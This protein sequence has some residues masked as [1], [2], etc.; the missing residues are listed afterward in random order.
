[1]PQQFNDDARALLAGAITAAATSL[2]IESTKADRF[3]VSNTASWAAKD[4]WFKATLVDPAT[5]S[6]EVVYVGARVAGSGACTNLLRGQ[7]GTAARAWN[8]GA[9]I[10]HGPLASDFKGALAGLFSQFTA[11]DGISAGAAWHLVGG[12]LKLA[13][14]DQLG[15]LGTDRFTFDQTTGVFTCVD[16]AM[17]SDERDKTGWRGVG[18]H[19]LQRL[20]DVRRGSFL[21]KS[22]GRRELGVS[23]QSLKPVMPWA[24]IK[25]AT[26]GELQVR[27][28]QAALV[29]A[30]E[31][32]DAHGELVA[33]VVDL[34]ERLDRL[35]RA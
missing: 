18:R 24:V 16:F 27:Y 26:T 32:A 22:T 25:D 19:F 8:S 17:S 13:Q 21:R 35:E 10:V 11:T 12:I 4:N 20:A 23:A 6:R 33:E 15:T 29:A 9:V 30:I 31:L 7:D 5:A 2:A 1:M 34:R 14:T 3:P 28:A